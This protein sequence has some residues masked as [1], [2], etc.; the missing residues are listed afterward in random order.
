MH[1]SVPEENLL[2][3]ISEP[4]SDTFQTLTEYVKLF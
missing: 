1:V 2:Q 4:A 3:F